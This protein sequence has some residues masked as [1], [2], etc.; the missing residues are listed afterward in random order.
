MHSA[1]S[2]VLQRGDEKEEEEVVVVVVVVRVG[3]ERS[4]GG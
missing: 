4:S 1:T 2:R 3:I